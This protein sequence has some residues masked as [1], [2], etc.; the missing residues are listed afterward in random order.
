M[1]RSPAKPGTSAISSIVRG[2]GVA[3]EIALDETLA[4]KPAMNVLWPALVRRAAGGDERTI[5]EIALVPGFAG[6]LVTSGALEV[7]TR[8]E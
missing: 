8:V 5:E 4:S 1:T 3:G 2:P 6:D 7:H